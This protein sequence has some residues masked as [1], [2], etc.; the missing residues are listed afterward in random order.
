M[1]DPNTPRDP[2]EPGRNP[3]R[4]KDGNPYTRYIIA[5]AAVIV[6]VLAVIV[7]TGTG[8][9][10]GDPI[11]GDPAVEEPGA[12]GGT[13]PA[14]EPAAPAEQDA[15]PAEQ[16]AAPADPDAEPAVPQE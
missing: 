12:T 13:P 8:D 7:F 6:L 9:D 2:H 16:D 1:S 14:D 4:E 15:A 11:A 3:G 10:A 5:G